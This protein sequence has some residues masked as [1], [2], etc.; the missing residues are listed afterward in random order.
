MGILSRMIRSVRVCSSLDAPS[1]VPSRVVLRGCL[2]HSG[3]NISA[4]L[5]GP[6][7]E[8]AS[9]IRQEVAVTL[10]HPAKG[11]LSRCPGADVTACRWNTQATPP[12]R[13]ITFCRVH[14]RPSGGDCSSPLSCEVDKRLTLRRTHGRFPLRKGLTGVHAG[15]ARKSSS[16]HSR[17]TDDPYATEQSALHANREQERAFSLF[18]QPVE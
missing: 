7:P 17:S 16:T 9:A 6:R 1:C 5:P 14:L 4:M 12:T 2:E 11:E 8:R 15:L 13:Q 3:S 18:T 10:Q